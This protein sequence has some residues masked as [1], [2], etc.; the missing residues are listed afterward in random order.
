VSGY[1]KAPRALA[2]LLTARKLTPNEWQLLI[3]V[4]VSGADRPEGFETTNA[5]LAGAIGVSDKT[6]RR[7]LRT[8]RAQG[9]VTF[10]DHQGKGI[11]VVWTT[12]VLASLEGPLRSG[13]RSQTPLAV[14]E[15]TSDTPLELVPR[16]PASANGSEP[17]QPRTPRAHARKTDTETEKAYAPA[18]RKRP[19]DELWDTFA[20]EE[21]RE[22]KTKSE[23]GQWNEGLGQ[24]RKIG[25]TSEQLRRA[26]RA[27]HRQWPEM[28]LTPTALAKHW[29]QFE[30]PR[31]QTPEEKRL[32]LLK[33]AAEREARQ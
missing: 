6:T 15:V 18:A 1:W 33:R 24:L 29:S 26:I 13:L 14:T 11:F 22:P 21:R 7:A 3:F 20:E 19:R 16:E 12:P 4:A 32:A 27:Y 28:T 30:T 23:R 25:A 2:R 17:S 5:F 8:L 9:F 10:G 31:E